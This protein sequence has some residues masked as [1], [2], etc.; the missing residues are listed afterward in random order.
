MGETITQYKKKTLKGIS[1]CTQEKQKE[2]Y[3]IL[4]CFSPPT[5]KLDCKLV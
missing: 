1:L 2:T 5:E 4:M 3:S